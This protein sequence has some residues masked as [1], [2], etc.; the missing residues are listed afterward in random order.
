MLSSSE[1]EFRKSYH[2]SGERVQ[3]L[4][5]QPTHGENASHTVKPALFDE[6]SHS[7]HLC[8]RWAKMACHPNPPRAFHFGKHSSDP[9][10]PW[11]SVVVE[12]RSQVSGPAV[13]PFHAQVEHY[14]ICTRD[15]HAPTFGKRHDESINRVAPNRLIHAPLGASQIGLSGTR[16]FFDERGAYRQQ[17]V[18]LARVCL[19]VR[20]AS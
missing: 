1:H 12:S 20:R 18:A 6:S 15:C 10:E 16:R 3:F 5:A 8:S 13:S 4:G 11:R 7:N 19:N 14:P 2:V 9:R 17:Q